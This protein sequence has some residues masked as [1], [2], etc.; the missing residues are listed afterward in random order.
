[1]PDANAAPGTQ[2]EV[3]A[4]APNKDRPPR[5]AACIN[6]QTVKPDRTPNGDGTWALAPGQAADSDALVDV[7]RW[8]CEMLEN[9]ANWNAVWNTPAGEHPNPTELAANPQG[10][11]EEEWAKLIEQLF[12]G[13]AYSGPDIAAQ[14]P[15]SGKVGSSAMVYIYSRFFE[16]DSSG[17]LSTEDPAHSLLVACQ[18]LTTYG[19]LAR[20][21]K[22]DPELARAGIPASQAASSL[23]IF[24]NRWYSPAPIKMFGTNKELPYIKVT[25]S[26]AHDPEKMSTLSSEFGGGTI[27]TYNPARFT[28]FILAEARKEDLLLD[29]KGEPILDEAGHAKVDPRVSQRRILEAQQ[30][31]KDQDKARQGAQDLFDRATGQPKRTVEPTP[32]MEGVERNAGAAAG[33]TGTYKAKLPMNVQLD[34]SHVAMVLRRFTTSTGKP[35]VQLLDTTSHAGPGAAGAGGASGSLMFSRIADNGGIY[36]GEAFHTVPAHKTANFVGLGVLPTIAEPEKTLANIRRARP[37]GLG[38]LVVAKREGA[39]DWRGVAANPIGPDDIYFISKMVRLWGEEPEQN[40]SLSR[41]LWSLR[42]TPYRRELQ[43]F[44]IAYSP[45]WA[46]AEVMW[47]K[48]T[49]SLSLEEIATEAISRANKYPSKKETEITALN[50]GRDMRAVAVLSHDEQ[51]NALELWRDHCLKTSGQGAPPK[52]IRELFVDTGALPLSHILKNRDEKLKAFLDENNRRAKRRNE[53][54]KEMTSLNAKA[55]RGDAEAAAKL[56]TLKAE[57]DELGSSSF[58]ERDDWEEFARAPTKLKHPVFSV[59]LDPFA[60]YTNPAVRE[61]PLSAFLLPK[62]LR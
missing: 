11:Y 41:L 49:R 46:L 43:A 23:P 39:P 4:S 53:I 56:K 55:A 27:Y 60:S 38:R 2:T 21:V 17:A 24:S 32:V 54:V 28:E 57:F 13:A 10:K 35:A 61:L 25:S 19:A 1:M 37:V 36:A 14:F 50:A 12:L 44:W 45:R 20:G 3:S 15:S 16:R 40:Y 26:E 30:K 58:S 6:E 31:T 22:L 51:G 18:T 47:E 9:T 42:N 62:L 34:G 7:I 59:R 5:L 33:A 48:G 29:Q 52:I 8:T